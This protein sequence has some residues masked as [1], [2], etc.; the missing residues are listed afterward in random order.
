MRARGEKALSSRQQATS[1][2]ARRSPRSSPTVAG[3]EGGD[4]ALSPQHSASSS[5]LGIAD[6]VCA[7]AKRAGADDADVVVG[8]GTELSVTV[9]KGEVENIVEAS[10]RALG[11]RVIKGGRVSVSY[12]SD[13][14]PASLRQ[15][16]AD[17]VERAAISDVDEAAGLPEEG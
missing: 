10:S 4:S 2:T 9:R 1:K 8:A 15:F 14:S 13:F 16:V 7:Q 11:L 12:S 3:E 6:D 5:L 17:A